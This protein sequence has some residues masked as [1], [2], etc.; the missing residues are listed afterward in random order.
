MSIDF[1]RGQWERGEA[2]LRTYAVRR[3]LQD[4]PTVPNTASG[5][6]IAKAITLTPHKVYMPEKQDSG[7]G[8]LVVSRVAGLLATLW[9]SN[10]HYAFP[11]HSYIESITQLSANTVNTAIKQLQEAGL[12]G[13]IRGNMRTP[14]H[15]YPLF[16]EP[17]RI[18]FQKA[19][20]K[21]QKRVQRLEAQRRP[22]LA[23]E[24]DDD[25]TPFI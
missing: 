11:S 6:E 18:A 24:N 22:V 15:Y 7:R 5:F 17:S 4:F 14:S 25:V 20:E 13:V 10:T 23:T 3:R 19:I 2:A 21:C 8:S 12:F 9:N 1:N 16:H